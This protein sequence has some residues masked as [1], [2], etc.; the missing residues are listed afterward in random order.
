MA[1]SN[2]DQLQAALGTTYVIER[3]LGR[4]GMATVYLA[5]DA[6]LQRPVALKVLQQDLAATLGPERFR[7]EI[8]TVAQLQHPHILGVHDSGETADGLLWF[9][10][11]YIEGETLRDRLRREHQLPLDDALRITREIA[12]ALDY[13]HDAGVIHRDIK[14][15]NILLTK[16]GDALLADFGIARA[17]ADGASATGGQSIGLT[18][19]GLAVG[20]PQ[21]MS[22]EQASGER[23][24]DARSDVYALGAVCYEMLAGEPPFSGPSQ[25]AVVAKMLTQVAPSVRVLRP[26][27]SA[28]LDAVIAR[29]LARTPAD[30]W[31]SAGEFGRAMAAAEQASHVSAAAP[32]PAVPRRPSGG[33]PNVAKKRKLPVASL[34]L[35]LGFLIGAGL[36][37]AWRAKVNGGGASDAGSA[38]GAVRLAVLPFE[39]LGDTADAYFADGV[40][41]AVRG[42]LTGVPGLAVIGSTSSGAYRHTTKTPQQIGDELGVR[43]LLIG[44]VRWVKEA[45]GT[46]KVQVSPE[47]VDVRSATDTWA[48]AF[49]APITDVFQVQADIAD[50]VAQKLQVALTPAAQ[51]TIAEK[52]TKD[53]VAYDA[54]L[55][56]QRLE[57][58]GGPQASVKRQAIA[59]YR[60]AVGRDSTF[61]VAWAGMARAYANLYLSGATDQNLAD[62]AD[63]ISARALALAPGLA[64]AHRVRAIYLAGILNDRGKAFTETQAALALEPHSAF[65]LSGMAAEEARAGRWDEAIAHDLQAVQL[66]PRNENSWRSLSVDY[67]RSGRLSESKSALARSAAIAPNRLDA[68]EAEITRALAVGDLPGARAIA[69]RLI[70]AGDSAGSVAYLST[71]GDF[72]WIFDSAQ[73]KY[74]LTLGVADFDNDR[75]QLAFSRAEQYWWMHDKER[76]R[77]W[78]DTARIEYAK[79][80]KDFPKDAQ[81]VADLAISLAFL[82]RHDEAIAEGKRAASMITPSDDATLGPYLIYQLARVYLALGE[83]DAAMDELEKVMAVP[84]YMPPAWV[85][86]NPDFAPLK[87]NPRLEKILAGAK[88]LS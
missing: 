70:Q 31:P 18:M 35:A 53:V 72:G 59:L 76:T 37:F 64:I 19:T 60:E 45:N 62:S 42:K 2:Q 78:A 46:S 28:A 83:K 69:A 6:K 49:N 5:R 14:P 57:K 51:Q 88:A 84:Y 1:D 4:G 12:G 13:A 39:N 16:R 87:G 73:T 67:Y 43:Y 21:Y 77:I 10:M 20:T 38:P 8:A 33:A 22:P 56:A 15:E 47:L 41:D 55:R 44:K 50:K 30:R 80:L 9:T 3:E 85:R 82:G 74:M 29:A 71:Y 36:L 32:P 23:S 66:D 86:I 81:R 24:L 65:A 48:G 58:E 26:G 40:T 17:L 52:P 61:A 25:Q 68:V 11:P 63:V 54:F 34:T 7:R 75:A 27:V 79:Q